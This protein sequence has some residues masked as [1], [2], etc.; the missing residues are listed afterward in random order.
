MNDGFA[1]RYMACVCTRCLALCGAW[2][3]TTHERCERMIG[4][5]LCEHNTTSPE[6]CAAKAGI[7]LRDFRTRERLVAA[8]RDVIFM[9]EDD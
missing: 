4:A 8:F 1:G 3:Q 6:C 7:L 5:S 9:E 2:R